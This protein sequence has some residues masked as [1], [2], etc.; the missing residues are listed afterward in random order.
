MIKTIIIDNDALFIENYKSIEYF[1]DNIIKI[2][3]KKFLIIINGKKIQID[4]FNSLSLKISGIISNIEYII[5]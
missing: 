5:L 1:D 2:N 3:C 4:F